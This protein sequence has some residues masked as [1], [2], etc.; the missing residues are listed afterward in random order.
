MAPIKDKK[1]KF[2]PISRYKFFPMNGIEAN[3]DSNCIAPLI[4]NLGTN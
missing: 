1:R 2:V 3:N 4:L